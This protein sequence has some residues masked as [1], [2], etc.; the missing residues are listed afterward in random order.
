MDNTQIGRLIYDKRKELGLTQQELA[1]RLQITNKAVSKWE[2]G[3][4]MPDINLLSP[5]AAELGLSVDELLSGEEEVNCSENNINENG[6][7]ESPLVYGGSSV[8]VKDAVI[9]IIACA[10]ALMV[11]LNGFSS[12]IF[13]L[14]IS[15]DGFLSLLP[16]IALNVYIIVFWALVSA[17]FIC[18]LLRIFDVD[19]PDTKGLA[20][21]T[22]VI[23]LPMLYIQNLDPSVIS[24]GVLFFITALLLSECHGYKTPHKLFYGLAL[25]VTVCYGT[26]LLYYECTGFSELSNAVDRSQIYAFVLKLLRALMFYIIYG[27]FE[28]C[29]DEYER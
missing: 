26:G 17:V 3:D 8:S 5:L 16:Y 2:N 28:K 4:G 15:E 22:F 25:L 27:A 19:I 11:A 23:G 9:G 7:Y 21:A 20:I 14:I 10:A 12:I 18:K 1:D 24:Y 13:H 6:V 29:C